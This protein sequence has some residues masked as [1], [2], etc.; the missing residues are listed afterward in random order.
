M[1]VG[2]DDLLRR[3]GEGGVHDHDIHPD[4]EILKAIPT[5]EDG[6]NPIPVGVEFH[7]ALLAGGLRGGSSTT[8]ARQ[9]QCAGCPSF[10]EH[11]KCPGELAGDLSWEG[12]GEVKHSAGVMCL[13]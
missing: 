5:S 6:L 9:G 13:D 10:R 4:E 1:Q 7:R 12:G 2:E 11:V 3:C 8:D